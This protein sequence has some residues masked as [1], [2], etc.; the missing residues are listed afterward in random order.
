MLWYQGAQNNGL[1]NHK[2]KSAVMCTVR[3]QCTLAQD[4]L[5]DERTSWK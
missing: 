5:T 1:S 4:R 2:L 3:S